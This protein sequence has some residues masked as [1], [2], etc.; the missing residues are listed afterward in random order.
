MLYMYAIYNSAL[1]GYLTIVDNNRRL[2]WKSTYNIK[3]WASIYNRHIVELNVRII[4]YN[5]WN[6][7][8]HNAILS[9][10]DKTMISNIQMFIANCASDETATVE[11][12]LWRL[13]YVLIRDGAPYFRLA[14]PF[15]GLYS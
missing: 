4:L 12:Y 14:Y 7:P 5:W 6:M 1:D 2:G 15:P 8:P 10:K 9:Q 13:S 11:E 3:K